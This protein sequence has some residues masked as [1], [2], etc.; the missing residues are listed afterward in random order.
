MNA[1]Q[2]NAMNH[3]QIRLWL[4]RALHGQEP[5]PRLAPDESNYL[6][7]LRLDKSL[8]PAARKSLWDA[9][10][11]L[12]RH[13]CERGLGNPSYIQE[14][15]SL[16]AA[17]KQ[18]ETPEMLADL[19]LRFPGLVEIP[20]DARYAVLG[21]L[22]DVSPPQPTAFWEKILEQDPVNYAS[23]VLAGELATNPLDAVKLLP[24]MPDT[25]RNGQAAAINLDI[26]WDDLL[27]AQR[28]KFVQQV[29]NILGQ[30][31]RRFAAPVK[32]WADGKLSSRAA[33]ENPALIAALR[34]TLGAE[35]APK[36]FTP[37]LCPD[38]ALAA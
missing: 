24:S 28:S 2:I 7:V 8:D 34:K 32:V 19:A 20:L 31:G 38:L 16:A 17:L 12:L 15:L 10:L 21:V 9:V 23:L 33:N 4:E 6:G 18:P 37:K 1:E 36:T 3:E 35:S 11:N 14:L 5:L 26:A 30:C 13:F 25:E 29:L 27:K 22:V